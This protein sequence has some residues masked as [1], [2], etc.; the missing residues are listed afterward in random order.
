[1]MFSMYKN[2]NSFKNRENRENKENRENRENR[3]KLIFYILRYVHINK[4]K[5]ICVQ[6]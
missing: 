3:E 6:R 5:E 4:Y 2:T 1:M